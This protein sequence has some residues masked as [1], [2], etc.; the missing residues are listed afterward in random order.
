M[1]RT[2]FQASKPSGFEKEGFRR[3][4][5][6]ISVVQTQNSLGRSS[7]DRHL[8]KL[9]KEEPDYAIYLV[10]WSWRHYLN[11]LGKGPFA[12]ATY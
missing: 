12:N 8:D 1:L 2:N 9:D 5:V 6:C 4:S 10:F 7:L 11:K 3:V